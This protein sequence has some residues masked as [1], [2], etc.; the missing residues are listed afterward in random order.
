M[1]IKLKIIII[2]FVG[3]LFFSCN[4]D[5]NTIP[6][7]NDGVETMDNADEI[8]TN[9]TD[10]TYT[11]EIEKE[12]DT[13]TIETDAEIIP[14]NED[15]NNEDEKSGAVVF[16]LF[17]IFFI[18]LGILLPLFFWYFVPLK[19]WYEARLSGIKPG[20]VRFAK[21]R[22]QGIPQPL[23]LRTMIKAKNSGLTLSVKDMMEKYL[24]GVDVVKIVNTSIRATNAGIEI[25]FND[26]AAQ[27]LAKVDVETVIHAQI[28]AK[29]A[30]IDL[31]L[32]EL[33]SDYLSNVDVLLIVEA[34]ITA[35][36]AKHKEFTINE[37]R[38]HYLAN[39]NVAKTVDAYIAAK[40]AS[41][42]D[43]T[44]QNIASI[45]LAGIDVKK[46]VSEAVNPKVVETPSVV[47]V[48]KDG[49]QLFMKLKLSLRANL[50]N[51]IGGAVEETVL[52][53][54]DES[55]ATEIGHAISHYDVLENPFL[56]ADKVEVKNLGE[57]TAYDVVS[58]DVSEINVGKDVHAE[59]QIERAHADA[60]TAK[61]NLLKA[62]EKVQKAMAAA[63]MDGKL[64][65]HDYHDMMNTE[66]D[67]HMRKKLGDSKIIKQND[68]H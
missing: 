56:L 58:V 11:D 62:E 39:G 23:I 26:L 65:I 50:K 40:E 46:A 21:M 43:V 14:N 24:A 1:K 4:S 41:I 25:P 19:L 67:T 28:T 30:G 20:W 68:K 51:Y 47:G 66:A 32:N 53:R 8:Y 3:L 61:T 44:F 49:I 36:N 37:L 2:L 42:D 31:T 57:G 48:A 9:E 6:P 27:S 13:D 34:L 16:W 33:A 35:H 18:V 5:D 7:D 63:F 59:L 45:D 29:N 52:A 12:T 55:L 54:I 10:E 22:L 38:E 15:E 64:T 60:E 17:L